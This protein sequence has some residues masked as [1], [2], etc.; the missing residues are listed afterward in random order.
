[1][2]KSETAPT[3]KKLNTLQM[4]II[5]SKKI[6]SSFLSFKETMFFLTKMK[7]KLKNKKEIIEPTLLLLLP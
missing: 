1:M 4:A 6:H 2:S 7:R 3:S 5:C